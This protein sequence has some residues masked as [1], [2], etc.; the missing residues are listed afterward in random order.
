MLPTR[1]R[2]HPLKNISNVFYS[3]QYTLYVR[4]DAGERS[5]TVQVKV[6][7][8]PGPVRNLSVEDVVANK[9]TLTWDTPAEDGGSEITNYVVEK[10]ETSRVSWTQVSAD[11]KTRYLKIGH[12]VKDNEYI[13]RY[14]LSPNF[15]L[16]I[17]I[18]IHIFGILIAL[19]KMQ[20]TC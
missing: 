3:G 8:I 13:F 17:Y 7:D 4:N 18:K 6:L 1:E 19:I 9:C 20:G 16:K 2:V 15:I 5:L 14:D 12:L 11:V 10:R